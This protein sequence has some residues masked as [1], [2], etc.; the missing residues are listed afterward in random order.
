MWL[1]KMLSP[2]DKFWKGKKSFLVKCFVKMELFYFDLI[3]GLFSK[4]Y[5]FLEKAK[6][7]FFVEKYFAVQYTI[8]GGARTVE[9]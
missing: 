4:I 6:Q 9:S 1:I 7:Q 2:V 5:N 3:K 8:F